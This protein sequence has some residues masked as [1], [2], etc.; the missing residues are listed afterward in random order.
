MPKFFVGCVALVI[1]MFPAGAIAQKTGPDSQAIQSVQPTSPNS[2]AGIPGQPG[3][4]SGPPAKKPET[5]GSDANSKPSQD[6]S[7]DSRE[8]RQQERSGGQIAIQWKIITRESAVSASTMSVATKQRPT[9][10]SVS[11]RNSASRFA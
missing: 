1:A 3:N 4:E 5:T 7:K 10:H 6:V 8:A 11:F 2:G 9:F